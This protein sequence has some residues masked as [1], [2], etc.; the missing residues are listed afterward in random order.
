MSDLIARLK[1]AYQFENDWHDDAPKYRTWTILLEAAERIALLEMVAEA[2][3][4]HWRERNAD[5]SRRFTFA[6]S[7]MGDAL[8]AAGYLED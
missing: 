5:L 6:E 1:E 3:E 8:R 7:E 2:A 4:K